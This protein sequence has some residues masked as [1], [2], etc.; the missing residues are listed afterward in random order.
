M[1]TPDQD[2]KMKKVVAAAHTLIDQHQNPTN[3]KVRRIVRMSPTDIAPIL[4]TWKASA[5]GKKEL[6]RLN[7]PGIPQQLSTDESMNA[8]LLAVLT[9]LRA[10]LQTEGQL[11][12]DQLAEEHAEA[13]ATLSAQLADKT[14]S[15][16]TAN[17]ELATLIDDKRLLNADLSG[18]LKTVNE[19]SAELISNHERIKGLEQRV[20]QAEAASTQAN[21]QAQRDRDTL[22]ESR[23]ESEKKLAQVNEQ[24]SSM[25]NQKIELVDLL[26]KEEK[27]TVELEARQESLSESYSEIINQRLPEMKTERDNYQRE[28]TEAKNKENE[29]KEDAHSKELQNKDLANQ[30][31]KAQG[32]KQVAIDQVEPL[33]SKLDDAHRQITGLTESLES[34]DKLLNDWVGKY[35]RLRIEL[36]QKIDYANNS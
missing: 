21:Q 29:A 13:I 2:E 26:L 14:S 10:Q 4:K 36:D 20:L 1:S 5:I 6:E 11:L 12:A 32:E 7:K 31:E 9:P 35:E 16:D 33:H 24:L 27:K 25:Q 30:L 28:A 23:Q 34:K 17:R 19:Q 8:A 22:T 15:L 3:E 18:A